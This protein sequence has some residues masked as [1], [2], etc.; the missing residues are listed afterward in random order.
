MT[1]FCG[2]W[3]KDKNQT[4]EEKTAIALSL[5]AQIP[6]ATRFSLRFHFS[7]SPTPSFFLNTYKYETK[8]T[9]VLNNLQDSAA[10]FRQLNDNLKREIKKAAAYYT[11]T[12]SDDVSVFLKL[13]NEIYR[14]QG[15]KNPTPD[16]IWY[17]IEDFLS[18]KHMRTLY[19]ASTTEG[20]IDAAIYIVWDKTTAYYL[21]SGVTEGGRKNNAVAL[22]LWQALQ[23]AATRVSVFDFE[24]SSIA[25]VAFFFKRFGGERKEYVMMSK[26]ISISFY[27]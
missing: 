1:P 9:F 14:R 15:I 2:I 3:L 5:L 10:L 7:F 12:S 24:G 19:F 27:K 6:K 11:I 22:L 13:Q 16:S 21:A 20:G 26:N 23:D 17:K 8:Q 4:E 18:K 25:S